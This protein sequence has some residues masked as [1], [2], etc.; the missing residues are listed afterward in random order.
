M[1]LHLEALSNNLHERNEEIALDQATVYQVASNRLL[2]F[3]YSQDRHTGFMCFRDSFTIHELKYE[4]IAAVKRCCVAKG[5]AVK[6]SEVLRAAI[7]G[8]AAL[9]DSAAAKALQS[10]PIIKSG[11]P[12]KGQK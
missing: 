5:L 7:I 6:K 4:L 12:A 9:S 3:C 2:Q 1:G 10:L 8:F 11:R